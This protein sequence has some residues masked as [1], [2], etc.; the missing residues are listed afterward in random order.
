M[1]NPAG[2]NRLPGMDKDV[3]TLTKLFDGQNITYD[4]THMWLAPFRFTR[5]AAAAN[6]SSQT[7]DKREPNFISIMFDRPQA[8]SAIRIWNYAKTASR[9]VHEFELVVD[10][11]PI[12]RGFAKPATEQGQGRLTPTSVVFSGDPMILNRFA[13]E[14]HFDSEK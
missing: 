6:S 1:V 8:I 5:S 3:R 10:D 14:V 7:S 13:R 12:Y 11:K 2:I 9:G 4:E